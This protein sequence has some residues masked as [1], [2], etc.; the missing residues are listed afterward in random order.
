MR[1]GVIIIQLLWNLL[2]NVFTGVLDTA[3]PIRGL[4][5]THPVIF[6]SY[7]LDSFWYNISQ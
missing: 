4:K 6:V 5:S 7:Q 3:C 1:L 2:C